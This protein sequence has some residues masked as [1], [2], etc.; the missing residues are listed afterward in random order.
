MYVGYILLIVIG[1]IFVLL[2]GLLILYKASIR[3]AVKYYSKKPSSPPYEPSLY[4][5]FG[6]YNVE[7]AEEAMREDLAEYEIKKKEYIDKCSEWENNKPVL[8][9]FY[10]KFPIFEIEI[11]T[12]FIFGILILVGI[13]VASTVCSGISQINEWKETY[14]MIEQVIKNGSDLENIAISQLKIEYNSWLSEAISSLNTWGKWS[15]WYIWK[16]KLLAL[17]YII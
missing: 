14:Q 9:K 13:I 8:A 7:T 5:Y 1:A 11:V 16:D 17:Q 3:A 12:M 15:S 2:L 6:F 10:D 4:D